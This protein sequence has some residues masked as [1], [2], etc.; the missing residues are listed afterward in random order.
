MALLVFNPE[1]DLALAANIANFTAPHAARQLRSDLGFIPAL[2]AGDDDYVLVDDVDVARR[3]YSRFMHIDFDRFVLKSQLRKLSIDVVQP[4]G[5]DRALR[6]FLLRQGVSS[7]FLP[8][9]SQL[10]DIRQLSH[11]RHAMAMLHDL[12]M[13][14]TTGISFIAQQEADVEKLQKEYCKIVVKAPWSSSGRGIRFVCNSLDDYQRGW[15]RNVLD[16]QGAVMV[17]PYYSKVKDFGMEF[18]CGRD[19]QVHY[20]G[21]SLF[22]THNGA[23]TGNIVANENDKIEALSCYVPTDLLV[24]V[25]QKICHL[26]EQL[27][28]GKFHG[29]F[30]VD[31]MVVS[32]NDQDGFLL[33]P[34]VE[35]N[36]RRTMGHVALSI[37][38]SAS[39]FPYVMNIVFNE[40]NYKIKLKQL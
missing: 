29:T 5:W 25:R 2:W 26:T 8:D 18:E 17:E 21:L 37:P 33:H 28:S 6:A 14:G 13:E 39:G 7:A 16:R 36:L 4:W 10:D 9:D 30:G 15:L 3:S 34:C 23:Y 24:S 27:F 38:P 32:R 12:Q 31:M 1:H 40:N 11:R 22:H 35:I 20:L 19:G